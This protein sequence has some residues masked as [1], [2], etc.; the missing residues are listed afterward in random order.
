MLFIGKSLELNILQYSFR[1]RLNFSITCIIYSLQLGSHIL[2]LTVL[3]KASKGIDL[4][5]IFNNA[6]K[7]HLLV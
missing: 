2:S 6:V 3:I 7:E 5:S 4:V 1:P